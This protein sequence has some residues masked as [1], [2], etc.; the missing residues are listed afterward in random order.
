M[1]AHGSEVTRDQNATIFGGKLQDFRVRHPIRDY[2]GGWP[3]VN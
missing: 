3:E 2:A 1:G